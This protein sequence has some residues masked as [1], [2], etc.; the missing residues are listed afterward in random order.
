MSHFIINT[1]FDHEHAVL[2]KTNKCTI[3]IIRNI[4]NTNNNLDKDRK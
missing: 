4:A 1:H 2:W 3:Q